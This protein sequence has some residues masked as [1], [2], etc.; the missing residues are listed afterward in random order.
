VSS[1]VQQVGVWSV[2]EADVAR[3]GGYAQVRAS[4]AFVKMSVV[5]ARSHGE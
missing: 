1:L 4:S 2:R 3:A 5:D